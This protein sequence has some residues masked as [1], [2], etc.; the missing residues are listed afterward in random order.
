M[1]TMHRTLVVCII[2]SV[3]TRKIQ[4]RNPFASRRTYRAAK[5]SSDIS[6]HH[7]PSQS[8]FRVLVSLQSPVHRSRNQTTTFPDFSHSSFPLVSLLVCE[9][10][11]DRPLPNHFCN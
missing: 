8:S 1:V 7:M 5:A 3:W 2:V 10:E 6:W 9:V 4:D 11:N